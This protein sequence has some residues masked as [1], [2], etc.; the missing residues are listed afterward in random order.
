M[1]AAHMHKYLY[2]EMPDDC[3]LKKQQPSPH[4]QVGGAGVHNGQFVLTATYRNFVNWSTP[5]AL[6]LAVNM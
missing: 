3:G 6:H 4:S 5:S 2:V 1:T